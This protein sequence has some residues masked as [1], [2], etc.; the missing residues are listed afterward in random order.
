MVRALAAFAALLIT[1]L[2]VLAVL[3]GAAWFMTSHSVWAVVRAP[4]F[5]T[6]AVVFNSLWIGLWAPLWIVYSNRK[7][8]EGPEVRPWRAPQ[9][10]R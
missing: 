6:A 3:T 8:A 9:L 5:K 4:W 10:Q 2:I 1:G 7:K